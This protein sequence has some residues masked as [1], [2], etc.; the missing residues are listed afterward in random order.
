[1]F[2]DIGPDAEEGEDVVSIK[3]PSKPHQW[4]IKRHSGEAQFYMS[5]TFIILVFH[6][7][8]FP[9]RIYSPTQPDLLWSL[10]SGDDGESVSTRV[11]LHLGDT[12]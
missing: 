5:S 10:P 9:S 4:V 7:L 12:K 1:M 2:A 6:N 8:I 11:C 3:N